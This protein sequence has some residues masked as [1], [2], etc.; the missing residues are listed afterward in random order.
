[1]LN[2]ERNEPCL[3]GSGRKYKR[4]CLDR[5]EEARASI[6][7]AVKLPFPAQ[8]AAISELL[9]AAVGLEGEA[10]DIPLPLEE[11]MEAVS[12]LEQAFTR[13]KGPDESLFGA[14]HDSLLEA[15]KTHSELKLV[16]YDPDDLLRV[17][18]EALARAGAERE[19]SAPPPSPESEE[20]SGGQRAAEE[21]VRR[22]W[23]PEFRE[24]FSL[25]LLAALRSGPTPDQA[26]GIVWG[27]WCL[28]DSR[29]PSENPFC[30]AVF[31]ATFE[32]LA[33]AEQKL[34]AL[35]KGD[36]AA[37]RAKW[38]QDLAAILREH[39]VMDQRMSRLVLEETAEAL[40]ALRDGRLRLTLPAWAPLGGL[41]Y[42]VR[43]ME[44]LK[45]E[46]LN[47]G[48]SAG[49]AGLP[50]GA[51]L[52]PSEKWEINREFTAVARDVDWEP[53]VAQAV[54]ALL[55]FAA[56]EDVP[57]S[58]RKSVQALADNLVYYLLSAQRLI[59]RT[60]YARALIDLTSSDELPTGLPQGHPF[61]LRLEDVLDEARLTEYAA[62]LEDAGQ[63]EA[64]EHV[65]RVLSSGES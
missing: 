39:P 2:L 63:K 55:E 38:A 22:L 12:S 13:E 18:N 27:A 36:G 32:D 34:E 25:D 48:D 46:L 61:T 31:D 30:L 11:A 16:R 8:V 9:G 20:P 50:A 51:L 24:R 64:A 65:R 58:L 26:A 1:L 28:A 42:I 54:K 43:H 45:T 15:L 23:S 10:E 44:K 19:T 53:V 40:S 62:A 17:L 14:L 47:S 29:Q 21:T 4:C 60:V 56:G 41:V 59:Y 52:E 3:C 35:D 5:V 7:R 33:E 57:D 6:R 37:D 49:P